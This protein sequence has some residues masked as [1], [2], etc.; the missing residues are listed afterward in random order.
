MR[1]G[2]QRVSARRCSV[3]ARHLRQRR[4]DAAVPSACHCVIRAEAC[5]S[6]F[7]TTRRDTPLVR[8]SGAEFVAQRLRVNAEKSVR[9]RLG[10][11]A[12]LARVK[13]PPRRGTVLGGG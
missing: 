12:A 4:A 5:P 10:P 8:E 13:V 2:A 9:R 3:D 7:R 11:S 6:N 1:H